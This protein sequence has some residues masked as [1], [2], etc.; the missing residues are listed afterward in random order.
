NNQVYKDNIGKKM[1]VILFGRIAYETGQMNRRGS[2]FWNDS[3]YYVLSIDRNCHGDVQS[4]FNRLSMPHPSA[5]HPQQLDS[6]RRQIAMSKSYKRDILVSFCGAVR[7]PTRRSAK[8]VCDY[9]KNDP[10]VSHEFDGELCSFDDS[11]E[12]EDRLKMNPKSFPKE[13]AKLVMLLFF[14]FFG[15]FVYLLM[16]KQNVYVQIYVHV[17]VYVK[18]DELKFCLLNNVLTYML[19]RY[20]V[21]KKVQIRQLEKDF[22]MA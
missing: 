16:L 4:C 22:G 10:N 11:N 14:F 13:S 8:E 19:G 9:A 3:L 5:F 20:F 17:C 6:L 12:V 15:L 18:R 1:H 21:S 7:T 2:P